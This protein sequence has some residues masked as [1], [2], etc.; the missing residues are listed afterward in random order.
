MQLSETE[1]EKHMAK[2]MKSKRKAKPA[3]ALQVKRTASKRAGR[4]RP[5]AAS[6]RTARRTARRTLRR[7]RPQARRKAA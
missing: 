5:K 2:I 6:G 3:R 7:K 4:T 1:R